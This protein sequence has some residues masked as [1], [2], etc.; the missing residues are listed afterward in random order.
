[1]LD[2]QSLV[3]ALMVV[4]FVFVACPTTEVRGSPRWEPLFAVYSSEPVPVPV[5]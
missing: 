4:V 1:M 2:V 3:A 5:R